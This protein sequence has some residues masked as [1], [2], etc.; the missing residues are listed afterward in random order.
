[1]WKWRWKCEWRGGGCEGGGGSEGRF[2]G[3][4]AAL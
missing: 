3:G 2:G 4:C 1:M